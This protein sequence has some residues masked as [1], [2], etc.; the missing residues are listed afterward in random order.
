M[1][2]IFDF[3]SRCHL[4]SRL[5]KDALD[6]QARAGDGMHA[7]RLLAAARQGHIDG[8]LGEVLFQRRLLE[9]DPMH[10]ERSLDRRLRIVDSLTGGGTLG[11]R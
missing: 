8:A 5:R 6:A 4:K 11:G 1:K 7:P 9:A 3:R 2:V 10:L